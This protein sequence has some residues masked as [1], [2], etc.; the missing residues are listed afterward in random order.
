MCI[1]TVGSERSPL[2]LPRRDAAFRA[3]AF[4]PTRLPYVSSV[5]AYADSRPAP[6]PNAVKRA[7][8]ALV[9]LLR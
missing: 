7:V 8:A 3:F 4:A 5:C 9:T 6:N 2:G 1:V